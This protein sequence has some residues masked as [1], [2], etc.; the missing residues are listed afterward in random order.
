MS[1]DPA[2]SRAALGPVT[3]VATFLLLTGGR[4]PRAL[5]RPV[6][7]ATVARWLTLAAAAGV[8]EVVWR[9]VVLSGL[10]IVVGSWAALGT[11][12]AAFA[13]WHW[14]SFGR[15]CSVHLVTGAAFGGAFLVGGLVAAILGHAS[16][17]L[18]VDCAV[19]AER[20]RVRG[21]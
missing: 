11:S 7:R 8:E 1:V 5:P 9:G 15:W 16:Y 13:V 19:H 2:L 21:P 12:S 6:G 18:L 20:A 4:L 10:L 3:G 17:N 14:P